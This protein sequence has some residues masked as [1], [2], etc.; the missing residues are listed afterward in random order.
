MVLAEYVTVEF[1][2]EVNLTMRGTLIPTPSGTSHAT[3]NDG[4]G[5]TQRTFE[6]DRSL[7]RVRGGENGRTERAIDESRSL[8]L[9]VVLLEIVVGEMLWI[10]TRL[11]S[12]KVRTSLQVMKNAYGHEMWQK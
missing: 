3:N 11:E 2:V 6:Q 7:T 9:N 5:P 1:V 4:D 12:T 8:I 10:Y